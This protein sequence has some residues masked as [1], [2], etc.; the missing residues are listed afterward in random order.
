[1]TKITCSGPLKFHVSRE[2]HVCVPLLKN[3]INVPD[4]E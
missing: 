2:L 4:A 3:N 1:M